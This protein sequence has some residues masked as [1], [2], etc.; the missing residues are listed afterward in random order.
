MSWCIWTIYCF[1]PELILL[2]SS[3][4]CSFLLFN[5]F[6]HYLFHFPI[7]L[8]L[9]ILCNLLALTYSFTP[10]FIFSS[11]INVSSHFQ[12]TFYQLRRDLW[13]GLHSVFS[14]ATVQKCGQRGL[15]PGFSPLSVQLR[16]G[17]R[18]YWSVQKPLLPLHNVLRL[19]CKELSISM[20]K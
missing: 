20:R 18:A 14:H 19:Y 1:Y 4:N 3:H 5:D 7:S 10:F 2:T 9:H 17:I 11:F 8:H 6:W 13:Q 12:C 16:G 15:F